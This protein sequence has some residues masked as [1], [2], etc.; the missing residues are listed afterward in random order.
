[1]H[2]LR[3]PQLCKIAVRTCEKAYMLAFLRRDGLFLRVGKMPFFEKKSRR[4]K[5]I[6]KNTF[7]KP[8]THV[9]K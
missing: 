9:K 2:F 4:W 8:K 1:M 3:K 6:P 5:R 7:K